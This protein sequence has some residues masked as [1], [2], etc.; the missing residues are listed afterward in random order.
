MITAHPAE[1]FRADGWQDKAAAVLRGM[2]P[3]ALA[4]I[5]DQFMKDR[6]ENQDRKVNQPE[7]AIDPLNLGL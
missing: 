7:P 2:L 1:Y 5:L 6:L 3:K 4:D